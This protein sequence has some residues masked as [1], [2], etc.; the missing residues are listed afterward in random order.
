MNMK[1]LFSSCLIFAGCSLFAQGYK[2][3][4]PRQP[5]FRKDTFNIV[6]YGARPDGITLNTESITK[7][8]DECSKKGG[9]VVLIPE[10][11]WMT[12]P[13]VLKNNVQLHLKKNALLQFTKDFN[14]Y[15]LVEGNW[16]GVPQMRN[17]SPIS[18]VNATNIAITGY[19]IID[20]N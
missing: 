10:G 16:E 4:S 20:G 15:K 11:F 18:A 6:R 17:Q 2:F 12:G 13:I 7:A 9:G 19:G 8:I 1:L 3:T 14:Q 5:Q